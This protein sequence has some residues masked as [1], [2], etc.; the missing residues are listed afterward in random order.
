LPLRCSTGLKPRRTVIWIIHREVGSMSYLTHLECPKCGKTY[1]ADKPQT[2]C[3]CGSPLLARYDLAAIARAV[4]RDQLKGRVA[5]LWRFRELLPVGDDRDVV[6][7]GE[8]MT[9]M[10]ACPRLGQA[11][12][13][14][15]LYIKD[16]GLNPTGT[17]KARGAAV[18]VSK[19]RELGIR[20]VAM[21]TAG[22]AGGAWAAYAAKAGLNMYVVMPI[23]APDLAKKECIAA[24]AV[25]YLVKGLISDAG[26]I[27]GQA[28]RLHGWFDASTLKEPYRIEGKKTMGLEIAEQFEWDLPD[29][30]LYPTGGGVGIIGIYKALQEMQ[31]IG[32]IKEGV[33]WPKLISVQAEGCSP[34]VRAYREGKEASDFYS[35]ARTLAAGIRV[36]KALGDFLV[37]E[38]IRRT[39]GTAIAVTDE[40][41]LKAVRLV[42]RTEGMLICPEGAAAVAALPHLVKQGALNAGERVV[43]LNTG[44]GL[45]YPEL[46]AVDLPVLEKDAE[47]E[48]AAAGER[49][50][51]A[52]SE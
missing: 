26:K 39:G 19:A 38:A 24:G 16:E 47:L 51:D 33:R 34:I 5:S 9:P 25:T 2:L 15:K 45:K 8:G 10:L 14:P 20:T 35:G 6:T 32:W 12:G 13:L 36:P 3:G 11:V 42:A 37:L 52:G 41:I 43:V 23:D 17:F 49:T 30:I 22:N 46:I 1:D 48:V 4:K 28:A 50:G 44:S 18:G 7:L 21:P 27:I 29:A 31:A 40:E